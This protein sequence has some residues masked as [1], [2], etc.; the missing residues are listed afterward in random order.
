MNKFAI[1]SGGATFVKEY[2][3]FV[4]QGGLTEKWGKSWKIIEA[5]NMD[6]ARMIVIQ[7]PGAFAGLYCWR[8]GK[9][10]VKCKGHDV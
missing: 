4:S 9:D 5:E 7:E 10:S 6:Q 8:C 3:F 2:D 1:H